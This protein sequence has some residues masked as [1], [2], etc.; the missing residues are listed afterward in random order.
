MLLRWWHKFMKNR[1]YTNLQLDK[2]LV[3]MLDDLRT[4]GKKLAAKNWEGE[5]QAIMEGSLNRKSSTLI[6]PEV[7]K[8]HANREIC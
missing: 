5:C 1:T 7:P 8:W 3:R 4:G 6:I 2:L